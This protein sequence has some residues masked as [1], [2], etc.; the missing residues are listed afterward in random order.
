V[1]LIA[2]LALAVGIL[3]GSSSG[4][5]AQFG[6][7][8]TKGANLGEAKTTQYQAG[9]TIKSGGSGPCRGLNGT[10]PVPVEWPEQSVKIVKEDISPGAKVTYREIEGA[11][12][13]MIVSVPYLPA[14]EEAQ[15]VVTYEIKRH[16]MLLPEKPTLF[17]IPEKLSTEERLLLAPSIGIECRSTKIKTLAKDITK[18]KANAWEKVEALYDYSRNNVELKQSPFKGAMEALKDKDGDTEDIAALFIALCRA[19]NIPARTVWVPGTCYAEFLLA[20]DEGKHHW[21]PCV[22]S[23]ERSFGFCKETWPI[24][25]KGDNFRVPENPK[26]M[27][28]FVPEQLTGKGGKPI[29]KFIREVVDLGEKKRG[30]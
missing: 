2:N 23:G 4:A 9:M 15:V 10:L 19:A 25:Q 13:Q 18:D 16:A 22:M 21:I 26:S 17:V 7:Q 1:K 8:P 14:G 24:L 29:V 30:L 11:V 27:V 12:S 6:K 20:D 3:L 5:R 28:R